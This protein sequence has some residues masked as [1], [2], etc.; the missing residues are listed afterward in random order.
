MGKFL[1]RMT[2]QR[3]ELSSL[4][5]QLSTKAPLGSQLSTLDSQLDRHDTEESEDLTIHVH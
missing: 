4:N 2:V 1:R 3:T 5:S